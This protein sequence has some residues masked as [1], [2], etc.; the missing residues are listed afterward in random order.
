MEQL[1]IIRP[2]LSK[3]EYF[4]NTQRHIQSSAKDGVFT[5]GLP[6]LQSPGTA[7]FLAQLL[8]LPQANSALQW[9]VSATVRLPYPLQILQGLGQR[10]SR[11]QLLKTPINPS[12][13]S[14][15]CSLRW[16]SQVYR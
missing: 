15:S 6:R 10:N 3:N 7:D 1:I 13:L 8:P 4:K 11:A 14:R 12:W 16:L 2:S 9:S 5:G